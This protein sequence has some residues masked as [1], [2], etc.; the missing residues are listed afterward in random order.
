LLPL[1]G[2]DHIDRHFHNPYPER[3]SHGSRHITELLFVDLLI[4]GSLVTLTGILF[5]VFLGHRLLPNYMDSIQDFSKNQREYLIETRLMDKSPLI[6][7]TVVEGGLR[8]LQGVYLVEIQS[9]K[10]DHLS[11]LSRRNDPG[12]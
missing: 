11:C 2:H 7:K 1:W 12:K 8:N 9:E 10:Q 5:I 4:I 6:N 3:F